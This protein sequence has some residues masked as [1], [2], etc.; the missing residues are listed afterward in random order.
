MHNRQSTAATPTPKVFGICALGEGI[1]IAY[2]TY[3]GP[4]GQLGWLASYFAVC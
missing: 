3:F 2:H 4:L 1:Y